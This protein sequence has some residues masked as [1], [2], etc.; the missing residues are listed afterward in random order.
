MHKKISVGLAITISLIIVV[1]TAT[2]TTIATMTAYSSIVSDIPEREKMYSSISDID[3]LVRSNYYGNVDENAVNTGIANG[4]L[5]SLDGYNQILSKAEYE[6]FRNKSEGIDSDGNEIRTV[7][8]KKF[9][10]AGYVKFH[11]FNS[12]TAK[13]FADAYDIL[14]NNSVTSLILDVRNTDSI[15]IDTAADIIDMIVPIASDG[16]GAIATATGKDGKAVKVYSSDAESI[17]MPIAVIVNGETSGAGELIACDIR[18]FGKGT[19][20]GEKTKGNGTY[21]QIFELSD[22]GAVILTVARLTPYM[23]DSY[24]GT[25]V[26]PDYTSEQ[27]EAT[28]DLNKDNQFLQAYAIVIS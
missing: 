16:T 3:T 28:D 22:G 26:T 9:G 27:T 23:S 8:Y 14:S 17:S 2:I 25:G 4:Y 21:Q 19:V 20:V 5:S 10:T 7:T 24:N 6:Q 11:D 18:D 15:N 1:I 13:E 12:N